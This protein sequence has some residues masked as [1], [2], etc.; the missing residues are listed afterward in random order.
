MM[1]AQHTRRVIEACFP[2]FCISQVAFLAEGWD[3]VA[4]EINGTHVFRFAKRPAVAPGLLKE[5]L[6][7]SVLG[8]SMPLEI[9]RFEYTWT[10]GPGYEGTFVGYRKIA[11]VSLTAELW[12]SV[13]N[14]ATSG[15]GGRRSPL[16]QQLGGF[17]SAL[18]CFP[19]RQAVAAGIPDC[20]GL[21][22][23]TRYH[24]LYR[25]VRELVFSL[26]SPSEQSAIA[27][28]WE[29]FL[30]DD[31]NFCFAPALIHADL[32][33]E[34]ILF[35]PQ[36]GCIAGVID[37]EDAVIGDPALDFT[38]LLA[39]LGSGAVEQVL[40]AYDGP[41]DS[42]LV[43][44]AGFYIT[45]APFYE[46]LFGLETGLSEHVTG[47]LWCVRQAWLQEDAAQQAPQTQP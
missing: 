21:L 31:A 26:L 8:P 15:H 10:G 27:A 25:T 11:G 44:R 5:M 7:L 35:D 42:G 12:K 14:E 29:G 38:G 24:D 36:R 30:E 19:L 43:V 16:A 39:D 41:A 40:A 37:W 4:W 47:G 6:L 22:W 32:A 33:A 18:H 46:V 23:R 34:H 17:L 1:D 3:S 45:L 20:R 2:Q 13:A 28:R 9:P